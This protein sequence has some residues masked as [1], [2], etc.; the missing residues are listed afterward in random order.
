MEN[1]EYCYLTQK[2]NLRLNKAQQTFLEDM[3][4][5]ARFIYN[6]GVNVFN[7]TLKSS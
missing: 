6:Y 2:V 3:F 7:E 5:K 1:K 4:Y